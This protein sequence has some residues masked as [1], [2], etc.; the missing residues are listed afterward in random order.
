MPLFTL[1][2]ND[3]LFFRDGRPMEATGGHGAR[4]P[5]PSLIFDALHA[6]LHRAFPEGQRQEWEHAH[7]YG[8]SSDRDMTRARSQRFGSLATAGLFPVREN[9]E[10]LFPAPKDALPSNPNR[11]SLLLPMDEP[12]GASDLPRPLRYPLGN[13][14][15]PSKV[16]AKPWWSPTAFASYFE[17]RPPDQSGVSGNADLFVGEWT[18]GIGMDPERQTQ[19]GERIYSAE[20]L[21][22]QPRVSLG[23]SAALPMKGN[24]ASRRDCIGDLFTKSRSVIVGGQQRVCA[25]EPLGQGKNVA[26]VLPKGGAIKGTRVKW[27]LL[28]PAVFP[29]IV[30]AE[31][32][33]RTIHSHPGG[34]LPTW[35]SSAD[36]M[37]D[38]D[39]VTA[40]EILL[41]DGPGLKK[42]QRLNVNPGSRIKARLV[43]ARIPKPIVLTGW[44]ERI[45]LMGQPGFAAGDD[46]TPNRG[47]RHT[48]LAVP[49]GAVYYFETESPEDATK[50]A[51]ALNWHGNERKPL[52]VMNRRSTL[53]GEKGFGLG[54]C[55]EW[56]FFP[57]GG[58]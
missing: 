45:H 33:D 52:A 55:G 50:L 53:M 10:W 11:L 14:S 37:L 36:G 49:A 13:T 57:R 46:A 34:W 12:H 58:R 9:G 15:A 39:A 51:G 48:R 25:V 31:N 19:D 17:G 4:W 29:A 5:E 6:A 54:V 3:V 32:G 7:R 16:E 28:T 24:G 23:F 22:L 38:G 44:S 47:P 56:N 40:G 30:A 8:R 27:V 41:R 21:R 1:T 35:V 43:A 2:P 26:D 42:A 20:Y 18:T